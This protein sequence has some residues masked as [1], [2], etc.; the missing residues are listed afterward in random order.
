MP[1]ARP[2]WPTDPRP[3]VQYRTPPT[4]QPTRSDTMR[5]AWAAPGVGSPPRPGLISLRR[6]DAACVSIGAPPPFRGPWRRHRLPASAARSGASRARRTRS[7]VAPV[8]TKPWWPLV[9][10]ASIPRIGEKQ[11]LG[12]ALSIFR[13]YNL[14]VRSENPINRLVL[15]WFNPQSLTMFFM[16]CPIR[17]GGKSWSNCV[18]DQPPSASWQHRLT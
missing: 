6:P 12:L 18:S 8:V 15:Q 14:S 2:H 4:L 10:W 3:Y 1:D 17:L 13:R 11:Y 16:P 7:R 9:D 5:G